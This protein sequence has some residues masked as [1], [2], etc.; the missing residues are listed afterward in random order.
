M[1]RQ[2]LWIWLRRALEGNSKIMYALYKVV[3]DIETIYNASSETYEAW[4]VPQRYRHALA[5]KDT[6]R[7]YNIWGMC[8]KFGFSVVTIEED[9]FPTMLRQ[10]SLPPCILFYEGNLSEMLKRPL[11]TMIG[12]RHATVSGLASAQEM[13]CGLAGSGFGLVMG[14]AEGIEDTIQK[15]VLDVGGHAM[16]ILPCGFQRVNRRVAGLIRNVV[17]NGVVLSELLPNETV[18]FG[19]YQLRNRLLA[20]I[21]HGTFVVQAPK[22]SGAVM[23]AGFAAA[24][25][26]DVFVL[27]GN[28]RDPSF[29]GNNELLRDGAVPVIEYTDIVRYYQPKFEGLTPADEQDPLF[30]KYADSITE[31]ANTFENKLQEKIYSLLS[32]RAMYPEELCEALGEPIQRIMSQI[33]MMEFSDWV[34]AAPGGAVKLKS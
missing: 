15:A 5:D 29:A 11:L 17:N 30:E 4:G 14:V 13:A 22:K 18:D 23:T 10:I 28:V 26:R 8:Q 19:T 24:E 3:G 1:N 16:L 33:S 32:H 12:T 27:P 6:G 34:E 20:G 9:I 2:V 21:S 7:A 31:R 25:G